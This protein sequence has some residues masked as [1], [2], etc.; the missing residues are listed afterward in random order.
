MVKLCKRK[1]TYKQWIEDVTDNAVIS[2]MR[3]NASIRAAS[4]YSN[5]QLLSFKI[6]LSKTA[7]NKHFILMQTTSATDQQTWLKEVFLFV[8]FICIVGGWNPNW[9]HSAR[10]PLTGLLYLPR[11]IVRMENLVE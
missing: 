4:N 8:S 10:R 3:G 7:Y 2:L 9:V 1:G 11:V 6:V 5:F